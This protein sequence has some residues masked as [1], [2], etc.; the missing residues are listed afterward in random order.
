VNIA[1]ETVVIKTD[2]IIR[3]S[4]KRQIADETGNSFMNRER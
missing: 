4:T 3:D 2:L 1:S